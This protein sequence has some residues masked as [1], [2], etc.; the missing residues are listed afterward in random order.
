LRDEVAVVDTLMV[1][2]SESAGGRCNPER[3]SIDSPHHSTP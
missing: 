1:R 2:S 3:K